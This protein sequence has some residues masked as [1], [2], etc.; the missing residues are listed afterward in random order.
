MLIAHGP[1]GYLIARSVV[2]KLRKLK[3]SRL[4]LRWYYVSG[5]IGGIFPDIDLLYYYFV[6][7]VFS[8]RQFITHSFLPYVVIVLLGIGVM[9]IKRWRWIGVC[10]IAFAVGALSHVVADSVFGIA[11]WLAPLSDAMFGLQKMSWFYS[12]A[13]TTTYEFTTKFIM[14]VIIIIA[15]LYTV[16]KRNALFYVSAACSM[17]LAL[18]LLLFVNRHIYA[19]DGYFYYNDLDNDGS[20]NAF[21]FDIDDDGLDNTVDTDIDNDGLDNSAEMYIHLF[22]AEGSLYDYTEGVFAEVPLRIGFV[23]PQHLI[24]RMYANNGIF[25]GREM[26]ADYELNPTGYTGKP[27]DNEFN[28]S[29]ENWKTWLG[30]RNQLLP[31]TEHLNEYDIVFFTSGH[32]GLLTRLDDGDYIFEADRSHLY[33]QSVSLE[34]VI[35]REG[36]LSAIGRLLPKPINR[37]Y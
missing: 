18:V 10:T 27:T 2:P 12:V 20:Y 23:S 17:I 22:E 13:L 24:E 35:E 30:H 4:Q 28:D 8:H 14:E 15:A 29:V 26:A 19:A 7:A 21:D 1:L 33:T 16:M 37:Q 6:E 31:A 34:Q 25:F 11:A 5:F 36:E 3:P 32:V 9:L